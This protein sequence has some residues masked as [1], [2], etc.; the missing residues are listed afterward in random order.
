MR[1]A[2]KFAVPYALKLIRT[3][4]VDVGLNRLVRRAGLSYESRTLGL[5]K[6]FS[7]YPTSCVRLLR[8]ENHGSISA[9]NVT[10]Q[11]VSVSLLLYLITVFSVGCGISFVG[12]K[13]TRDGS[14]SHI[15]EDFCN[16]SCLEFSS[17]GHC[18]KFVQD[19]SD[20]CSRYLDRGRTIPEQ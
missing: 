20:I 17:D 4:N 14:G 9:T 2:Q 19:I 16:G 3:G 5:L 8:H 1:N 18:V 15:S 13:V 12:G 6:K 7:R 10:T 11:C